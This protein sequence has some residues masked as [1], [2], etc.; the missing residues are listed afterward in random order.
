MQ[1]VILIDALDEA[2]APGNLP[3]D[4]PVLQLMLHQ[5]SCLPRNVRVITS[6]RSAPHLM[7]PLRRK[8]NGALELSPT[9]VRRR[10]TTLAQLERRLMGRFG[11]TAAAAVMG[12][13]GG[14]KNLVYYRFGGGRGTGV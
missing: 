6:T 9:M 12:C 2:D 13:G 7:G 10:E 5:L 4:N 11:A 3:L 14:E 8:F 1:V